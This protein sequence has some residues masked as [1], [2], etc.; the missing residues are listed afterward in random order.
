MNSGSS[1]A[2]YPFTGGEY[3]DR[4][5]GMLL[6]EAARLALD[7]PVTALGDELGIEFDPDDPN[8]EYTLDFSFGSDAESALSPADLPLQTDFKLFLVRLEDGQTLQY[9]G[10]DRQKPSPLVTGSFGITIRDADEGAETNYGKDRSPEQLPDD[11]DHVARVFGPNHEVRLSD[12]QWD[13]HTD[14]IETVAEQV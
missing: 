13:L 6:L 11:V 1:G 12:P 14:A 3:P 9:L 4:T 7:D 10:D 2:A 5:G 8:P